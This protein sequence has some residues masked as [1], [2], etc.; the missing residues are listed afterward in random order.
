MSM[1]WGKIGVMIAYTFVPRATRMLVVTPIRMVQEQIAEEVAEL[2]LI[3]K[4]GAL[5]D[6]VE[7][8]VTEN[9]RILKFTINRGFKAE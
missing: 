5:P 2:P 7:R 3:R 1:G 8:T 4:L 6:D 9:S